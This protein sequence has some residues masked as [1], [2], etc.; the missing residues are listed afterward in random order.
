MTEANELAGVFP[1]CERVC[2]IDVLV[3]QA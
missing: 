3:R 1:V 2:S